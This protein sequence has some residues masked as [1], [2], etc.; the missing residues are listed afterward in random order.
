M[1]A[2]G[3]TWTLSNGLSLLRVVFA[4]PVAFL[5]LDGSPSATWWAA[6]LI[7]AAAATD[8]L[9]GFIARKR[10]ETSPLGMVL[11]PVADK[12]GIGVVVI[13]L[14]IK[15]AL[16][17]WFTGVVVGRDLAILIAAGAMAGRGGRVP[18]SNPVGKWTA[19]VLA[20]TVFCAVIDP[21]DGSGLL[22]PALWASLLMVIASAVSY[23]GRLFGPGRGASGTSASRPI[24]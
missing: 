10:N 22:A 7:V 13:V 14:A 24:R 5:L 19:A 1:T 12:F 11:D 16:P 20:A 4:V 3:P 2:T 23:A 9:D 17:W 18:Q 8:Y 21:R 15:G 6:V